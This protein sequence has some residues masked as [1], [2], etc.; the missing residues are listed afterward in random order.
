MIQNTKTIF[1]KLFRMQ[2]LFLLIATI[3]AVGLAEQ[4]AMVFG[5]ADDWD[6]YSITSVKHF[7]YLLTCRNH[8]VYTQI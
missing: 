7:S 6:N 5:T 3:C 2:K 1:C 4:Y 8:A